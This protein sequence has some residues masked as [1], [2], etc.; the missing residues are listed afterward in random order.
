MDLFAG[1]YRNLSRTTGEPI[2]GSP[3]VALGT[4][5]AF[6]KIMLLRVG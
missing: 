5:P 6:T 4:Q 3:K 1:E 2:G